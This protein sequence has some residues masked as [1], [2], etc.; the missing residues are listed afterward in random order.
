MGLYGKGF[1]V[2]ARSIFSRER[3]QDNAPAWGTDVLGNME[4]DS[5]V[6]DEEVK[7][8]TEELP[9]DKATASRFAALEVAE[10]SEDEDEA[11][12]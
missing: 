6:E 11:E 4:L 3:M 1:R 10:G 8:G 9:V 7:E 12:K 2:Y 5:E